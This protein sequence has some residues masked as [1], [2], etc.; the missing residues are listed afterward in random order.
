[1]RGRD[2]IVSA[3]VRDAF[4][5]LPYYARMCILKTPRLK[6]RLNEVA[7]IFCAQLKDL[8]KTFSSYCITLALKKL[9]LKLSALFFPENGSR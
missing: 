3:P 1:M 5:A 8:K 4:R 7:H 6:S 2:M 9:K